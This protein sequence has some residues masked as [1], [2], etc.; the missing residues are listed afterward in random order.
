M[1]GTTAQSRLSRRSP[2]RCT[3]APPPNLLALPIQRCQHA[4]VIA[5]VHA[6]PV[7]VIGRRAIGIMGAEVVQAVADRFLDQIFFLQANSCRRRC[8]YRA[9]PAC[10]WRSPVA[11][12]RLFPGGS[13][14]SPVRARV[15]TRAPLRNTVRAISQNVPPAV[16]DEGRAGSK[17]S[18]A[19]QQN[20]SVR[21]WR[22]IG[23]DVQSREALRFSGVLYCSMKLSALP[24]G[25]QRALLAVKCST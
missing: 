10:R 15:S 21:R 22:G 19:R 9:P 3:C 6:H 12:V 17:A 18:S 11:C 20:S 16:P 23:H 24:D 13:L 25:W 7:F 2:R 8:R 4:V 5:R 1:P 14:R